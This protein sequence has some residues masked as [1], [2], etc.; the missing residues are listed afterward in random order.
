M[1]EIFKTAGYDMRSGVAVC[2]EPQSEMKRKNPAKTWCMV[3]REHPVLGGTAV[4]MWQNGELFAAAL[5]YHVMREHCQFLTIQEPAKAK[6][7]KIGHLC[8]TECNGFVLVNV[9]RDPQGYPHL[10]LAGG[11]LKSCGEVPSGAHL[12][13][14]SASD[15]ERIISESPLGSAP[16]L[17]YR[18][19]L[20]YL[21]N[22]D[23][24]RF[25]PQ[26]PEGWTPD[27][28]EKAPDGVMLWI[29]YADLPWMTRD[30][31]TKACISHLAS[32]Y[33]PR[34]RKF[35]IL[36][37]LTRIARFAEISVEQAAEL[38]KLGKEDKEAFER[39][40]ALRKDAE[41]A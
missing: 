7:G 27:N 31:R 13:G 11:S 34:A 1:V 41:G 10:V 5:R 2:L 12:I 28:W 35:N 24:S 6:E 25:G 18:R 21:Q 29:Y 33:D 26:P 23:N 22:I 19:S 39:L 14:C 30:N 17:I 37:I 16:I 15:P 4:V 8:I 9:A 36:E 38:V 32:F 40:L 3:L 20:P